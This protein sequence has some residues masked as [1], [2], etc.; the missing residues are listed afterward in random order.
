MHR[1][2]RVQRT[3]PESVMATVEVLRLLLHEMQG[4]CF[5]LCN[6]SLKINCWR[7]VDSLDSAA[8]R[9]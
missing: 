3:V 7:I 1:Y 9:K 2:A 5:S 8:A 4:L 6:L